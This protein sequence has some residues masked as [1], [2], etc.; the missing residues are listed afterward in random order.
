MT[1][2]G[3]NLIVNAD[4]ANT[5]NFNTRASNF[6]TNGFPKNSI[7][8]T[9]WG[10]SISLLIYDAQNQPFAG[11]GSTALKGQSALTS[12]DLPANTLTAGMTY[13]ATLEFNILVAVDTTGAIARDF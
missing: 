1:W 12:F 10:G 8:L 5:F 3:E 6:A 9:Q 2:S 7:S 11:T 13:T 4:I